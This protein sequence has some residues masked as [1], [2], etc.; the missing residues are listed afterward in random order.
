MQKPNKFHNHFY[1]FNGVI[2]INGIV[3]PLMRTGPPRRSNL[4]IAGLKSNYG[5]KVKRRKLNGIMS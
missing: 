1:G 2:E 5:G 3:E 4:N